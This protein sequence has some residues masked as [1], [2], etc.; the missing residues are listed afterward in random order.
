MSIE[1]IHLNKLLKLMFLPENELITA[2]RVDIR[3]E[4]SKKVGES[5]AG[6][7][8]YMPFWSDAKKHVLGEI[9]LSEQT[10]HRITQL[11]GRKK[12]Y[13]DLEIG[14]L[15]LWKRGDNQNV[16]LLPIKPKGYLEID[17]KNLLVK[18]ENLMAISIDGH[19][20]LGYPYWFPNP[21]LCEEAAR[22]GLW[23]MG[24]ALPEHNK[25][26]MRIFDII[27]SDFYSL[28]NCPLLGD[29]NEILLQ[30]FN[31]ILNKRRELLMEYQ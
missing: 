17:D 26:N 10:S 2:L 4:F 21:T 28:K 16:H 20:R 30:N 18:V 25:E 22:I 9:D 8:F 31:R 19:E 6:G 29:E 27:R 23:I 13:S 1:K 11:A 14:F 3:Q 24:E 12:I 5:K 7:D 15:N